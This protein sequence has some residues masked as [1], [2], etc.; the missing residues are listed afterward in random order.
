MSPWA[1]LD[2]DRAPI[3]LGEDSL[4]KFASHL[5]TMM[6][7]CIERLGMLTERRTDAVL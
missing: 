2:A 3:L 5:R 4:G 6:P 1:V 7:W